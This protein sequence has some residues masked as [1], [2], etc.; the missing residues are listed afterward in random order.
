MTT[1]TIITGIVTLLG[2]FI[3]I[4]GFFPRYKK[5]YVAVTLIFLGFTIGLVTASLTHVSVQLKESLS[6]RNILGFLLFGF[7]GLLICILFVASA[8]T[9]EEKRRNDISKMGSAVSGFLIF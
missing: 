1:F 3:Q 9:L 4:K 5:Y 8:L 2:F 7:S 6:A